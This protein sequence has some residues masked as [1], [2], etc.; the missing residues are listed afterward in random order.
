MKRTNSKT[1]TK[2]SSPHPPRVS[3]SSI[4]SI[5]R[6]SSAG[7]LYHDSCAPTTT[8]T[9]AT[10]TDAAEE[11]A[12]GAATM[13]HASE[14]VAQRCTA[15]PLHQS[16]GSIFYGSFR[17]G[18]HHLSA[19]TTTTMQQ[20]VPAVQ[21]EWMCPTSSKSGL[22]PVNWSCLQCVAYYMHR[23][24]ILQQLS[25]ISDQLPRVVGVACD[26]GTQNH[27]GGEGG[28]V[29]WCFRVPVK[30]SRKAL[31]NKFAVALTCM[32]PEIVE[33]HSSTLHTYWLLRKC[34]S[35]S[36][37]GIV[38]CLSRPGDGARVSLP[39][40]YRKSVEAT[41]GELRRSWSASS[42]SLSSS[43]HR[44]F[45]EWSYCISMGAATADMD[46]IAAQ[47][48]Q[49]RL[50]CLSTTDRVNAA[51]LQLSALAVAAP[52]AAKARRA[53]VF[54]MP[55][56]EVEEQKGEEEGKPKSTGDDDSLSC[57]ST[58]SR[59]NSATAL[60]LS[61]L[62]PR[63]SN[64][65]LLRTAE[66]SPP[67]LLSSSPPSSSSPGAGRG[68]G[69]ASRWFMGG[70][71]SSS[72]RTHPS[73]DADD[74]S[75]SSSTTTTTAKLP[76]RAAVESP[77]CALWRRKKEKNSEGNSSDAKNSPRATDK[78]IKSWRSSQD[79]RS[80]SLS[81]TSA[82]SVSGTGGGSVQEAGS[83]VSVVSVSCW[84]EE[85]SSEGGVGTAAAEALP[86]QQQ[87]A[88]RVVGG[89]QLTPNRMVRMFRALL[90]VFFTQK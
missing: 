59:A 4:S 15:C 38:L 11:A 84:Q 61:L 69:G 2:S 23:G 88:T 83:P 71:S 32:L 12:A 62:V 30:I 74:S 54:A 19:S 63:S 44:D 37:V 13:R 36:R 50:L 39:K 53:M 68:G 24:I 51:T 86:Q 8:T 82:C 77:V 17:R 31:T 42:S 9:P 35:G 66:S 60:S 70:S 14:I 89:K 55:Q 33:L 29:Q 72:N 67:H 40:W 80:S 21:P 28:D 90:A 57:A 76:I 25:N 87:D 22:L 56:L 45:G 43:P 6:S 81:S 46:P 27:H 75:V 7:S 65:S 79:F 5:L 26:E 49:L 64:P 34:H 3:S 78:I 41:T 16:G 58:T 73:A 48:L 1:N 85:E 10:V 52:H 47:T 18:P 20:Q